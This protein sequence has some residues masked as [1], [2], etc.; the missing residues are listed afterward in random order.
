MRNPVLA[1]SALA[2]GVLLA[3]TPLAFAAPQH[4]SSPPMQAPQSQRVGTPPRTDVNPFET[5]KLSLTQAIAESQ[6]EMRGKT[7]DARFEIWHGRPAYLV[8][9]YAANQVWETRI[10]A[11]SGELIGQPA[12]V[13]RNELGPQLQRDVTALNDAQTGLEQAIGNAEQQEGGKAIRA[14]VRASGGGSA[15][16][17]V[18]L[19][20]NG[21]LRTAM[22]DAS[23]GQMR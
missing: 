17:D 11:N 21:R 10:D 8:R 23:T 9:T 22:V 2:A 15:L 5:A 3:A 16:Y 19:V 12:T 4:M 20:K 18:D 14:S 6:K 13:S 1:R 7:L